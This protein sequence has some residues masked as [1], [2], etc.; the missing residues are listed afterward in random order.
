MTVRSRAVANSELPLHNFPFLF[1]F[2]LVVVFAPLHS[3][4]DL[5]SLTR[6]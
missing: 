1:F 6:D 2:F 5:S 4:Q 3:L